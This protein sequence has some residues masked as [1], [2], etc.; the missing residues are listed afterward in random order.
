MCLLSFFLPYDWMHHHNITVLYKQHS[1]FWSISLS[2]SNISKVTMTLMVSS[3]L[4][5]C[6]SLHQRLRPLKEYKSLPC[7]KV[8]LL[9]ILQNV[10][11]CFVLT[12]KIQTHNFLF[13]KITCMHHT[14]FS[15]YLCKSFVPENY[16]QLHKL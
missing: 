15:C 8:S 1:M 9:L 14:E 11:S 7:N 16:P 12:F 5:C 2:F 3:L 4:H 10:V 6:F 13:D